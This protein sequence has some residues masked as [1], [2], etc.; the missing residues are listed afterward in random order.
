MSMRGR[1]F[2]A[3]TLVL[4]LLALSTGL[5]EAQGV[6]SAAV[7]GAI[8]RAGGDPVAGAIVT[9]L[10]VQKGT[11]LRAQT[12]A[13]GRFFFDNVEP[14]GPYTIEVRAIGFESL[15]KTGIM[16][17]LGQRY[18]AGFELSAQVVTLAEL[19]V[20]AV[21]NPLINSSRTGAEQTISE[22]QIQRLPPLGRNF[23]SL[24][25]SNP[26]VTVNSIGGSSIGGQNSKFNSIQIDGG[27]NNDIFG[28]ASSGTPGG[29]AGAKPISLEAL[30]EFQILIAPF[31]VRQGGFTGGLVN[32]VTKSGTNEFTGS[33]FGYFRN[34]DLVGVD[35]SGAKIAEFKIRQY[36]GTIGGPIIKDKVHFFAAYDAQSSETP[37]TG[38]L[39]TEPQTGITVATADR[40]RN[41]MIQR[42]DIDPGSWEE[43]I[44]ERPD[45]NFF[46]KI[47]AQLTGTQYLE[48]SNNLVDAGDDNLGRTTRNRDNRDGY[49]LSSSGYRFDSK[50]NSTRLKW[51]GTFGGISTEVIASY[52][53]VRDKRNVGTKTPLLMVQGDVA[54]NYL[55]AG[56]ERFSQANQLDQNVAE[57]TANI[58]F[59][60]G[61][62]QFTV[63]T[64]NEVFSFYNIFFPAS[65]GVW[66]F[67]NV[68]NFENAI[69]SKYEIALPTA[70]RPDGPVADFGVKQLG[71][72][73][74]D[75]WNPS[76]RLTITGGVRVDA[77]YSDTP[78]TNDDLKSNS[79][80]GGINTGDFPT[81]NMLVSP[82]LGFNWDATGA[83]TS[84]VR[85]G[86]GIFTGRPPYVW[87][88]NAFSN[89]GR[90]QVTLLCTGTAVPTFTIDY[91]N[92]PTVCASGG[93]PTPP[94][95]AVNYFDPDFKFQQ[96]L[97][98]A[99][100]F[101]HQF[102]GGVV[103]TIDFSHTRARNQ[104]YLLDDNL[105]EGGT[106]GEGRTMYG[107]IGATGS[108]SPAK[109][110]TAFG[111]VI[112]HENRSSDR[113]TTITA[114]INK[115]FADDFAFNASYAWARTEDV[116]SFTSSTAGSNLTNTILNGTLANRTL[117]P[118]AFDVPH[119]V[120]VSG[121]ANIP[122]GFAVSLIYNGVAGRPYAYI[123]NNDGN[124]DGIG[125]NDA[126]Y[127]PSDASDITLSNPA[128]WDKLNLW[129]VGEKCLNDHRGQL[130]KRGSCRNPWRNFVDMRIAKMFRT[131]SG[132]GMEITADVFNLL[133]LINSDWGLIRETNNF[134]Q[135]SGVLSVAGWDTRGT[136]DPADDRPKY[137]VS[138]VLPTRDRVSVEASRWKIQM[139]VK[140]TW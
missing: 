101:D 24:L 52:Q 119:K 39:A 138:S 91:D 66:T 34:K 73:L 123:L 33:L 78:V 45:L 92:Q 32:G 131:F 22:T 87:M 94:T 127:V 133:N 44:I 67:T 17:S 61:S 28:L 111:Q 75:Q 62:H 13:S 96:A 126:L 89:T 85:G 88:S 4:A 86:V 79:A 125:T 105:V 50:T 103:A 20:T 74:Q 55:A 29:Q 121:T 41:S 134:D 109:K 30:R 128:D 51:F 100:G 80:L 65:R 53:T 118:S 21:T 11:V 40:V 110:S 9:L 99:L 120:S 48:I 37:F 5:A 68:T 115:R 49:Q 114:Q 98:F 10:N 57:L 60:K 18:D 102:P 31:D 72:Y 69:P 27:V 64:H 130:M 54:G 43:P 70:S 82:R 139:G 116:M 129:L 56:G 15:T 117:T 108:A 63:G 113:S 19:T 76:D 77:P 106:N 95:A 35:T 132:Q 6:T 46:A 14:G 122:F 59:L 84:I 23:N 83:G 107:T 93:P 25:L 81:G 1:L 42:F 26:Q 36:G 12:Q 71:F 136:A 47:T 112:R 90:E 135:K 104:M 2:G 124:A 38:A 16:L 8:T 7:R 140:Y 58:S 97:K 137:S 3:G